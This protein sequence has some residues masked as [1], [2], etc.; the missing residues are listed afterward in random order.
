MQAAFDNGK[1]GFQHVPKT[2]LYQNTQGSLQNVN[3]FT[4]ISHKNRRKLVNIPSER[5]GELRV[6]QKPDLPDFYSNK[7]IVSMLNYQAIL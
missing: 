3:R 5:M 6:T 4:P 2:V 1:Y 7:T